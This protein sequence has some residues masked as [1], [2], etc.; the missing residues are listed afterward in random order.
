MQ[1]MR[2]QTKGLEDEKGR[3]EK[4]RRHKKKGRVV[5]SL[6]ASRE[7]ASKKRNTQVQAVRGQA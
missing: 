7:R 1:A 2:K 4:E 6:D 5:K 3:K